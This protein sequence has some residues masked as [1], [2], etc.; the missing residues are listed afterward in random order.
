MKD[1]LTLELSLYDKLINPLS[2]QTN[3]EGITEIMDEEVNEIYGRVVKDRIIMYNAPYNDESGEQGL[4][5]NIADIESIQEGEIGEIR[6]T[7]NDGRTFYHNE[8]ETI[9]A[10]IVDLSSID[11]TKN[12]FINTKK[13]LYKVYPNIEK[14]IFI[15]VHQDKMFIDLKLFGRQGVVQ[16]GGLRNNPEL[17]EICC[18]LEQETQTFITNKGE[19]K[20]IRF[21]ASKSNVHD[22]LFLIGNA[23]KR[24]LFIERIRRVEWDGNQRI[25]YFLHESGASCRGLTYEHQAE[26][27]N[28]VMSG[29]L[30]SVLERNLDP[31]YK[32]IQ[33]IPIFVGGQGAGKSML[34][35]IIGL[36]RWYRSSNTS[37]NDTKRFYETV[38]GGVIVELKESTQ[39]KED[40]MERT[41]A[42]SDEVELRYRKSYA[43]DSSSR[44][45]MF[46]MIATTNNETLLTDY[47]GNRRFYPVY[48]KYSDAEV[49]IEDRTE[50]EILQLWA[51]ALELYKAGER[52]DSHIYNA[53][54]LLSFIKIM[55]QSVLEEEIQEDDLKSYL[56]KE[57]PNIGDVV[58]SHEL[59]DYMSR[60]NGYYGR[61]LNCLSR[62]LGNHAAAYGFK[63][64]HVTTVRIDGVPKTT[65]KYVRVSLPT[66]EE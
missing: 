62:R 43:T 19:Q 13:L 35:R 49:K 17:T 33:F 1:D 10:P 46:T 23:H 8:K 56:D 53:D 55:Q 6:I 54:E 45:I 44:R 5:Y 37:F 34:C 11:L 30:L 29:I 7:L 65:R 4:S 18:R 66:V 48:I 39:F 24:N 27:L 50:D 22:I 32:P 26:Y 9:D 40:S 51:E 58:W 21:T 20:T 38:E 52:W 2:L 16:F 12:D 61:E 60:N 15:D 31:D 3:D 41:K 59:R 64:S 42:F 36:K 28:I 57:F 14:C 25:K 63:F 47:T